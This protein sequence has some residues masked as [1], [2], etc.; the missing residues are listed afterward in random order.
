MF[1]VLDM[2]V[3]KRKYDDLQSR[4]YQKEKE[5]ER[6]QKHVEVNCKDQLFD[7]CSVSNVLG[8]TN[9]YQKLDKEI[10]EEKM[11]E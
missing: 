11:E 8:E 2:F 7:I 5:I 6:L 3:S 10:H 4:Y 1:D 9:I